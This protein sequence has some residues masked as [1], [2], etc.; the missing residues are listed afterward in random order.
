L[1]AAIEVFGEAGLKPGER[2]FTDG[3]VVRDVD[4]LQ[5]G[6][7]TNDKIEADRTEARTTNNTA[8]LVRLSQILNASGSI[9]GR[10]RRLRKWDGKNRPIFFFLR[11]LI[12][13]VR[14]QPRLEADLRTPWWIGADRRDSY[15]ALTYLEE[16]G[17]EQ[18]LV[19][20]MEAGTV[21]ART[22]RRF[23]SAHERHM[24]PEAS[25][26][27]QR[28]YAMYAT[29]EVGLGATEGD[30]VHDLASAVRNPDDWCRPSVHMLIIEAAAEGPEGA[31][32]VLYPDVLD[33]R[34]LKMLYDLNLVD[35]AFHNTLLGIIEDETD[36]G[37]DAC[38][39][40]TGELN[41]L[42]DDAAKVTAGAG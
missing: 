9:M 14:E 42:L 7:V 29:G 18:L 31:L 41:Q 10:H 13:T 4:A 25:I 22:L 17:S 38:R 35:K 32:G 16:H 1:S 21:S 24:R 12:R 28:A 2:R 15:L 19:A 20:L 36:N 3:T 11:N 39:V 5:L 23:A 27:I 33:R 26:R 37:G 6:F 8:T 30:P 40:D 34:T